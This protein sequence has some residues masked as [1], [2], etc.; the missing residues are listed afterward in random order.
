METL[1]QE[2]RKW[3][4]TIRKSYLQQKKLFTYRTKVKD[5]S[6]LPY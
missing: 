2:E 5:I 1:K 3:L 6:L 4:I